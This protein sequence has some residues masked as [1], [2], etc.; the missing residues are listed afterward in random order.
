[1]KK[2]KKRKQKCR[3]QLFSISRLG[4]FNAVTLVEADIPHT[5]IVI[6]SNLIAAM[7][8]SH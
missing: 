1:M 6:S 2:L 4:R 3:K 5:D 8:D 7:I